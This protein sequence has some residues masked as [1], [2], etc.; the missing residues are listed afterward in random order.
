MLAVLILLEQKMRMDE[1]E[2]LQR[3]VDRLKREIEQ[4]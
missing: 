3:Q 1:D 4:K 2:R